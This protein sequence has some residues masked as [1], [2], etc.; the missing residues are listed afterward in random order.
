[1]EAIQK[2]SADWKPLSAATIE[3][4]LNKART[5]P[6]GAGNSESESA[7]ILCKIGK[8]CANYEV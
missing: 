4:C 7:F 8:T 3:N 5:V 6:Q 1:M 2:F